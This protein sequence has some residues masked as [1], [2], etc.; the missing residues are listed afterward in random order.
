[1]ELDRGVFCG[2][3]DPP[4]PHAGREVVNTHMN[5]SSNREVGGQEDCIP[6]GK[7]SCSDIFYDVMVRLCTGCISSVL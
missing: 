4:S 3:M 1:M 6:A 2:H 5:K 7:T